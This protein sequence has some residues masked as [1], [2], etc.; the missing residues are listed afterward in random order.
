MTLVERVIALATEVGSWLKKL[1]TSDVVFIIG[2][3]VNDLT[4][5]VYGDF[6]VSSAYTI[7][8]WTLL[9]RQAGGSAVVEISKNTL[10]NWPTVAA[11]TASAKPTL[12]AA[13]KATST[14]LTGWTTSLAA[15]DALTIAL[16]SVS[17]IKQL[18]LVLQLRKA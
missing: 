6:Q 3:N 16:N 17:G 10:A 12:S 8:G 13:Q 7:V 11:I 18:T 9:A 14:T 2:D 4:A 15:G 1:R 5:K